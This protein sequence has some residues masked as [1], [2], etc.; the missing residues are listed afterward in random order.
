METNGSSSL[1]NWN[2]YFTPTKFKQDLNMDGTYESE[3]N[4]NYGTNYVDVF[5]T[6]TPTTYIITTIGNEYKLTKTELGQT[7]SWYLKK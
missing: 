2:F 5:Y 6:T 4:C 7:Q 1:Q 3:Y